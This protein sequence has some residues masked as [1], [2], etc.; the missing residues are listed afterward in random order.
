MPLLD[1]D[2]DSLEVYRF[3]SESVSG[4]ERVRR[5]VEMA[6][7][8]KSIA[9]AGIR[10]RNPDFSEAEVH[11]E[12]LRLLHGDELVRVLLTNAV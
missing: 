4:A 3:A 6:E 12:W 5:A 1:T 7:D 2:L 10:F 9:I 8:A 11:A